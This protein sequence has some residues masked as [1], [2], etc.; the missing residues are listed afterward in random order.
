MGSTT[1]ESVPV[2]DLGRS[3][4]V[5]GTEAD[6]PERVPSADV[7]TDVPPP[8]GRLGFWIIT[9]GIGVGVALTLLVIVA[10]LNRG[11]DWSDEGFAF[12]MISSNRVSSGEFWGF[13]VLLNPLYELFGSSILAFR[14]LRLLGYIALSIVLCVIARSVLDAIG[15]RLRRSSWILVILVA[16]AGTFAAWSYPPRYLGYNELSSW[17]TQLAGAILILLLIRGRVNTTPPARRRGQWVLWALVGFLICGLFVAKITAAAALTVI[18]LIVALLPANSGRRW[19]RVG[20]LASGAVVAALVML[21]AGTPVVAYTQSVI[22]L[23]LNPD[24]QAVSGYSLTDMLNAYLWSASQTIGVLAAPIILA[25]VALLVSRGI[26][27]TPADG[28]RPGLPGSIVHVALALGA[29]ALFMVVSIPAFPA[30]GVHIFSALGFGTAFMFFA[31]VLSFAVLA[32][33]TVRPGLLIGHRAT[34]TIFLLALFALIPLVSGIGTLNALLGQTV[35]SATFWAVGAGVALAVLWERSWTTSPVMRLFPLLLSAAIVA[36]GSVAVAGDVLNHPYRTQPYFSQKT[37][38]TTGE[39]R[40]LRLTEGEVE[41]LEWLD[42]TGTRLDADGVPALS[43]ASPGALLAFNGSGWA[44]LWP[45]PDWANSMIR[46]CGGERPD[47]LFVLQSA[48]SDDESEIYE[49][50]QTGLDGCGV[51][52]PRDFERVAEHPSENP[53]QDVTVWRLR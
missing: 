11:F 52:F 21:V 24:D 50:L 36:A 5:A 27:R 30:A 6:A 2:D 45:G 12:A 16:Q 31:A 41:L 10:A 22:A 17:L 14:V 23:F 4:Q 28:G 25:A 1:D 35:F 13:Q 34:T 26:P 7:P 44:N 42:D 37:E 33:R 43:M 19:V 47:D 32:P 20:F 18:A 8:G 9:G 40:G 29:V 38:S 48:S 39:F 3:A 15:V 53:E 49:Q 51:D 46:A